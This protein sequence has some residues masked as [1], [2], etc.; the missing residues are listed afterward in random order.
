[1][2]TTKEMLSSIPRGN[3]CRGVHQEII[4]FFV[5]QNLQENKK[6]SVLDIPCGNGDLMQ[7]LK[8]FFPSISIKGCD[9]KKPFHI[10]KDDF[11]F[12]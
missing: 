2:P 9:I 7:S 5:D 12:C 10:D 3:T 8:K 11:F 1:M 4:K 6:K